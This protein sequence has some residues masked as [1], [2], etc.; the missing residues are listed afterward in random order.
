MIHLFPDREHFLVKVYP[1][2]DWSS[3]RDVEIEVIGDSVQ[4]RDSKAH[5]PRMKWDIAYMAFATEL[6]VNEHQ[7]AAMAKGLDKGRTLDFYLD[8]RRSDLLKAGFLRDLS[9]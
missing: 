4:E 3:S 5:L 7:L 6:D 1:A 9:K 8:C 2:S